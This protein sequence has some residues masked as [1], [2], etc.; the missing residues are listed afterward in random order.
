V[1]P[2][3]S[4]ATIRDL[5]G[6]I[7]DPPELHDD[8]EGNR[9][10]WSLS[11]AALEFIDSAVSDASA[12]LETGEGVSTLLFALKGARH[13]CV[14]P[15]TPVIDRI[16]QFAAEREIN[17]SPVTFEVGFSEAVLP[18]LELPQLDL[19][20][21]DGCHAFPVVYM[22]WYYA[23]AALKIGGILM[24]DDTQLWTVDVLRRVLA[25]EDEWQFR[26]MVGERTAV[27]IKI[28]DVGSKEWVQ[29]PYVVEM[30]EAMLPINRPSPVTRVIRR[31]RALGSRP[32]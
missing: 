26:E 23:A 27:F 13:T 31:A 29:Q 6:L 28:A 8:L 3:S 22:D 9:A 2:S 17:L 32:S 24:L 12:T 5:S 16:R 18:R 19:A 20:L 4:A 10:S 14:T 1:A 7:A 25:R 21:I 30:T 11:R 15:N